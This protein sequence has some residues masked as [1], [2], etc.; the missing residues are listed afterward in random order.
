[1]QIFN[2]VWMLVPLGPTLFHGQLYIQKLM[3]A[4][5][6]T[7]W[8]QRLLSKFEMVC[9]KTSQ[10]TTACSRAMTLSCHSLL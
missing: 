7:F 3:N 10:N 6:I 1:M 4:R 5:K 2:G 9:H 8:F